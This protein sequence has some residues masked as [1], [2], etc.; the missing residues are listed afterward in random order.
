MGVCCPSL[1]AASGDSKL[2]Q[3]VRGTAVQQEL[4]AA[5]S[6]ASSWLDSA[7]N[8]LLSG[9]VLLSE[10]TET[11]LTNLEV[12]KTLLAQKQTH[13]RI[14]CMEQR[15]YIS[16]LCSS[17]QVLNK[18]LKVMTSEVNLCRDLLGG[19]AGR[20]CGGEEQALME[21]TLDGLRD[22]MGLLDSTLEQHCDNMKD[23][24]QDQS[25]FQVQGANSRTSFDQI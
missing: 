11:Q 12:L 4:Y 3:S 24:L 17:F 9:P 25:S 10:D 18:Q 8:Q 7:E 5:V 13:F 15:S 16:D 22:R 21:D 23:R 2:V 19:G 6:A 1:Q 20:L 14:N